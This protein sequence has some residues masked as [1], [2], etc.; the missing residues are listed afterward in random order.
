MSVS[1]SWLFCQVCLPDTHA[2]MEFW[3]YYWDCQTWHVVVQKVWRVKRRNTKKWFQIHS[4][5]KVQGQKYLK[6]NTWP[7]WSDCS[8]SNIQYGPSSSDKCYSSVLFCSVLFACII[9]SS[10]MLCVCMSSVENRQCC[11]IHLWD[12]KPPD[13]R[14]LACMKKHGVSMRHVAR[15]VR[16]G[17]D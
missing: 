16:R 9:S 15:Q 8:C 13:H 6:K 10:S 7:T 1:V 17:P 11:H 2:L 14:G 3:L 12:R 4:S 5:L